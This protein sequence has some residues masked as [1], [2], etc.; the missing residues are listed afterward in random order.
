MPMRGG[1]MGGPMRGGPMMGGPMMGGPM[2]RGG[3]M[4][5]GPMR[6]GG[7]YLG[8]TGRGGMQRGGFKQQQRGQQGGGRGG[9]RGGNNQRGGQRG[10]KMGGGGPQNKFNKMQNQMGGM[11]AW[12]GNM[13]QGMMQQQV[14]NFEYDLVMLNLEFKNRQVNFNFTNNNQSCIK[15]KKFKKSLNELTL[16]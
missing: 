15:L 1:P 2:G 6:A 13:N 5:G 7:A 11:N 16:N 4:G 10:N 9:N 12:G 3:P 14:N 8:G